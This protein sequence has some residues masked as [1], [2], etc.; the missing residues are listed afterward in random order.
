MNI[1]RFTEIID[2]TKKNKNFSLNYLFELYCYYCEAFTKPIICSNPLSAIKSFIP[3]PTRFLLSELYTNSNKILKF[4]NEYQFHG[5]PG[6]R[7]LFSDKILPAKKIKSNIKFP[8]PFT[9]PVHTNDNIEILQSNIYY[10]EVTILDKVNQPNTDF[11][12]PCVSIGFGLNTTPYNSHV[13]WYCDSIGYHSDD[14]TMRQNNINN[15]AKVISKSWA[16]NDVAGA[17]MIWVSESKIKFFF[18]LNGKLIWIS[19]EP[20]DIR[21]YY[22]PI[23]G[24][25]H[26]NSISVNFSSSKFKY[27]IKNMI[28]EYSKEIISTDNDF[29]NSYDIGLYLNEY[30]SIKKENNINL[31]NI[32]NFI[33]INGSINNEN[34]TGNIMN[35]INQENNTQNIINL[36][37]QENNTIINNSNFDESIEINNNI[38]QNI[39]ETFINYYN[40]SQQNMINN[41]A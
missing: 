9:F 19:T 23:I 28:I 40:N 30:P 32:I 25:D 27:N 14:G 7:V 11:E 38:N 22:F 1:L 29:I 20:Y 21:G 34:N 18:T 12:S 16:N 39:I 24:Y 26:P 17:G 5:T 15:T 2:E 31:T 10:Y 13:G 3:L 6:H 36:I 8:I 4:N 35:L 37:N 33:N 41:N